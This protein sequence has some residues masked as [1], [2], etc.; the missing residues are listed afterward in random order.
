MAKLQE[1]LR[2]G[3][4]LKSLDSQ[5][6]VSFVL[7]SELWEKNVSSLLASS[8]LKRKFVE[9]KRKLVESYV[10]LIGS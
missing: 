5:G 4:R 9:R 2:K 1:F 10:L 3:F 8:K 6:K 7:G